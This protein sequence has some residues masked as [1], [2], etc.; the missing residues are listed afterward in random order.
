M[1][2]NWAG[3]TE[4][5]TRAQELIAQTEEILERW[6]HP[7]P[8]RPPTAPG[9]SKFE[10]NLPV[11]TTERTLLC[12]HIVPPIRTLSSTTTNAFVESTQDGRDRRLAVH[13]KA[14]DFSICAYEPLC[15]L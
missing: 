7:D 5:L 9:G 3:E 10:R 12:H 11:H 2:Y 13:R 4:M 15:L 8:Y 1:S 6:K 14:E